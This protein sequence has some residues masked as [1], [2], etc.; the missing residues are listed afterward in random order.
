[1]LPWTVIYTV[2]PVFAAR[3]TSYQRR[4]DAAAVTPREPQL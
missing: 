4:H 1:M 3:P 2:R